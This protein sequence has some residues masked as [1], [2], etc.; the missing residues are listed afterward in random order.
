M[1]TEIK[2]LGLGGLIFQS[3]N[4]DRLASFYKETLGLPL[5]LKT[6]GGLYEHWECDFNKI[7]FAILKADEVFDGNLVVPSFIVEDIE[8]LVND[9]HLTLEEDI[10]PLGGGSFVGRIKDPDGN[11]IHLWMNKNYRQ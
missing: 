4:P 1:S 3:P 9:R 8:K 5:E 2:T 6:H 7:H 11:R 10:L